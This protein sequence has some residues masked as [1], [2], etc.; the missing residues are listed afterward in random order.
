MRYVKIFLHLFFVIFLTILT[1]IG[2][3]I[4]MGT[5]LIAHYFRKKKRYIFPAIYLIANLILVPPIALYF[6]S[7]RLPI[8]S[9]TIKPATLFY[10][11]LFRNYVSPSLKETLIDAAKELHSNGDQLIY[12]D[13]NFPFFKGFPLL[14]HLSHNDRRKVDISFMYTTQNGKPTQKK[15]SFS[16][17]GVFVNPRQNSTSNNCIK[18]GYWQYDLSKYATFGTINELNFDKKRTKRLL[19]ILLRNSKTQKIFIEPYL[20]MAMGLQDQQKIRFHGCRAV[21]HD[22]HIHLQ[23]K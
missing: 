23:I 7:V 6:G 2:G 13:A 18:K 16:G 21:R 22:D 11:L 4:W 20:K 15:P 12:L 19:K 1:Q 17:Y 10:P 9:N 5:L 3:I 14:P 8:F